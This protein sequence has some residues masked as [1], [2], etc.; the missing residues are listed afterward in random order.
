MY[1]STHNVMLYMQIISVFLGSLD[2]VLMEAI[3]EERVE[4]V[5][6][7]LT[8]NVVMKEF[9]TTQKLQEL[10]DKVSV[11]VIVINLKNKKM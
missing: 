8:Q 5:A 4:F 9:L 6:L 2:D 7:I 10:Y 3:M 1:I 11:I